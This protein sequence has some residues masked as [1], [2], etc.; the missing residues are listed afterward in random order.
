M[1]EFGEALRNRLGKQTLEADLREARTF[2]ELPGA[3][4][5]I[6]PWI[7]SLMLFPVNQVHSL[8]LLLGL[9]QVLSSVKVSLTLAIS[10]RAVLCLPCSDE[11]KR[12]PKETDLHDQCS[13]Y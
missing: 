8:N 13:Y 9:L 3:G 2:L 6:W 12:G 4:A 11:R 10:Q 7:H 1:L 5:G